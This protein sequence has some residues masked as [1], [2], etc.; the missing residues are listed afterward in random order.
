MSAVSEKSKLYDF[1]R[2]RLS[3]CSIVAAQTSA[4]EPALSWRDN[5][6]PGI[7]AEEVE[8]AYS[9]DPAWREDLALPHSSAALT[10]NL[11]ARWRDD[12]DKLALEPVGLAE[13]A[14]LG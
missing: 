8:A 5:L 2:L 11:F 10:V 4:G 1:A 3:E 7:F 12:F 6:A 9:A 14:L 13:P